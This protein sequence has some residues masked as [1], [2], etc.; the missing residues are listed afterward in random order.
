MWLGLIGVLLSRL[1]YFSAFVST[2]H[3][4]VA[5]RE[6]RFLVVAL[7]TAVAALMMYSLMSER[8]WLFT[9]LF[10]T[11]TLQVILD[12]R[13]GRRTAAFWLLPLVYVL[14]ANLHI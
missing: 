14:W 1:L 9:I 4:L 3:R 12:L 11:I 13:E 10:S 7:L 6:P 5:R 2:L 8:P